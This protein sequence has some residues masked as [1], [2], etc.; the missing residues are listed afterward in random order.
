MKKILVPTDFSVLADKAL[1]IAAEIAIK[2]GASIELI[3]V[4]EAPYEGEFSAIGE[5]LKHEGLTDIFVLKSIEMAD[6]KMKKI[7]NEKKYVGIRFFP[8]IKI[9]NVFNHFSKI[10]TKEEIDLIVMGTEGTTGF[11]KGIFNTSNTE[12]VVT[13]ADCMVLSIKQSDKK[14]KIKNVVLASNFEDDSTAFIENIKQLQDIFDFK[15]HIVCINPLLNKQPDDSKI[16]K[17]MEEFV[18]SNKIKNYEFHL[19][20]DFTE[21]T[22]LNAY[23]EK[24][25]A[26][27]IALTTHQGKGISHWL[28]GLSEDLVNLSNTPVLTY[29]AR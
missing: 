25:N 21:Y 22:G 14:F 15:F 13:H 7:I 19:I 12:E 28:G 2:T 16:Q 27:I 29:K 1:D 11:L 10:I 20:E 9:G 4:I 5:V 6:K 18:K 3:H 17:K 26:D 24:I 23:A 8:K